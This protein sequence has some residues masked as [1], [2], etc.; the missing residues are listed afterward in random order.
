M[1]N[2]DIKLSK[3]IHD[4]D[5]VEPIFYFDFLCTSG[6]E[7]V[8]LV[9]AFLMNTIYLFHSTLVT[10]GTV[11]RKCTVP[12]FKNFNPFDFLNE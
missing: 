8:P 12:K 4:I 1:H 10:E 3:H 2:D 5:R 7:M 9:Y 11:F 6:Y